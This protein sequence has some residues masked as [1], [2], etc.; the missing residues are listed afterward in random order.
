MIDA[1]LDFST[2]VLNLHATARSNT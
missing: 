2:V 1:V